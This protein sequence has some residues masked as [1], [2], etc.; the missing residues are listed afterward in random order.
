M[1]N[2]R[3]LSASVSLLTIVIL[4]SSPFLRADDDTPLEGQMKI[5][6]RSMRTL[7]AQI[8]DPAKQQ[9]N[10]SLIEGMKKAAT[11]SKSLEP[12]MARTVPE[13]RRAAFLADYRTDLDELRDALDQVEQAVK[14]GDHSKAQSLLGK[15][16]AVKKEAHGKFKRD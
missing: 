4:G 9:E 6:A 13:A 3:L 14:A 12:S 2:T 5:L 10:V 7:S 11:D 15:V 8:A 16:G 1:K